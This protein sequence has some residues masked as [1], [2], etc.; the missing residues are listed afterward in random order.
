VYASVLGREFSA[1]GL[2][3]LME[4]LPSAV[5]D[6]LAPALRAGLLEELAP[7]RFQFSHTLL[8]DAVH[9]AWSPAARCKVHAAAERLLSEQS[10]TVERMTLR[11]AHALEAGDAIDEVRAADVVSRTTD[12]LSTDGA[13]DRA[14][15]I[16]QR[17]LQ[18]RTQ[19]AE[20]RTLLRAARLAAAAGIFSE[21]TRF[22]NE[23]L[24]YGQNRNDATLVGEAALALG[25]NLRPAIVDRQLVRALEDALARLSRDP[26]AD[27]AL[28]CRVRARLSAALQPAVDFSV[29]VAMAR[30]AIQE[31][32]ALQDPSLL[33]DV[34]FVAGSTLT[35]SVPPLETCELATELLEQ[36]RAAG[37]VP[38]ML[39]AQV[40]RIMHLIE[41][42]K[43]EALGQETDELLIHAQSVG[44][45]VLM[46]RPL[47]L[48][49]LRALAQGN[50][51]ESERLVGEIEELRAL[52]D[53]PALSF[54]LQTH[55]AMRAIAIEDEAG[56]QAAREAYT[57]LLP[58]AGPQPYVRAQLVAHVALRLGD[59]AAVARELD[60]LVRGAT[61]GADY[62]LPAMAGE[63]AAMVGDADQCRAVHAV[64][65]HLRDQWVVSSQVDFFFS[66][67]IERVLGLLE[68][69]IGEH[70]QALASLHHAR[71]L[72]A[73][74][75]LRPWVARIDF[76][77]GVAQAV[78]GRNQAARGAFGTALAQAEA[79]PL[80]LTAQR[81]RR[82]LAALQA[83]DTAPTSTHMPGANPRALELTEPKPPVVLE[84]Q[85][86]VWRVLYAGREALL[87]DSRGIQLLARLISSPRERIH[88][89][90]LAS[91]DTTAL[92][93]SSAGSALDTTALKRYRARL[94][95]LD[96]EIARAENLD[97][98]TRATRL[99]T[100]HDALTA[101]L[102]RAVG[103]GGRLREVGSV[104]ERARVNV[105]RR[106]RD[107]IARVAEAH[108]E[109]GRHLTE[110]IRTG[111]Y[112][113]FRP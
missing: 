106:L 36:A 99:Q 28:R 20:A 77:L 100:E 60:E 8:R 7:G 12:A 94:A 44:L 76:E 26:R 41:L 95:E 64:L 52:T 50:F 25:T 71:D 79:L 56:M 39:R 40:R 86:Q 110:S 16:Y 57:R 54:G 34:L 35:S 65:E 15:A 9:D 78:A 68:S 74:H 72:C 111:T 84:P 97:D 82:E 62:F 53:D 90:A 66:G 80:P 103:L 109:L 58:Q 2:A 27:P 91:D 21:C 45:P 81:I 48:S 96:E 112:C 32:R 93:E 14:F 46:W 29:P 6:D 22:A 37:D 75:G 70:D 23:A 1:G 67:P 51:M 98:A 59:R 69:A 42:G 43:L 102:R 17:W 30:D 19:P 24:A 107:A 3:R 83:S 88:V 105:T 38:M 31:A 13:H 85:G 108:P 55:G 63:V 4:R 11:A 47:L 101:E 10:D 18:A 89:L 33:R 92:G 61:L 73:R 113:C 87:K 104:T 5:V 49:S